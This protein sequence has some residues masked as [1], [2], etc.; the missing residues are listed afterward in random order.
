VKSECGT[1]SKNETPVLGSSV[2]D[3]GVKLGV[4]H[5]LVIF[6]DRLMF[7]HIIQMV[8]AKAFD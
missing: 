6:Q 4:V 3:L 2:P 5:I 1:H 8:S 7:N